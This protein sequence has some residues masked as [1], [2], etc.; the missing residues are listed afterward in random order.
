MML[1]KLMANEVVDLVTGARGAPASLNKDVRVHED[2]MALEAA[3]ERAALPLYLR[4][5]PRAL[6][7]W[8]QKR[9]TEQQMIRLWEIS[10][11]LLDDAGVVLARGLDLPDH[12]I[13]APTR[14]IEAVAAVAPEQIVAAE[15]AYPPAARE[16]P[17]APTA[18]RQPQARLKR[19]VL[20]PAR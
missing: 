10:P 4:L 5:M 11:H 12:L 6:R 16:E 20:A 2:R 3:V 19:A 7:A 15:L 8:V 9:Q 18:A 1:T 13:A 14:V 17:T